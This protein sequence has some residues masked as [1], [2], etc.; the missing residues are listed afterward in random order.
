MQGAALMPVAIIST[1]AKLSRELRTDVSQLVS[2]LHHK[3][4]HDPAHKS[5]EHH[6]AIGTQ[7]ATLPVMISAVPAIGCSRRNAVSAGLAC[8]AATLS[9]LLVAPAQAAALIQ[10]GI[11]RQQ[12]GLFEWL[13]RLPVGSELTLPPPVKFPRR[14]L[15]QKFAVLLMQSCYRAADSMDFVPMVRLSSDAMPPLDGMTSHAFD[16]QSEHAPQ[17]V[18]MIALALISHPK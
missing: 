8:T 14:P 11:I 17:E 12:P 13:P 3:S 7:R 15:N 9:A 6:E 10:D 2:D 4:R 1:C 16:V 18:Y 5:A